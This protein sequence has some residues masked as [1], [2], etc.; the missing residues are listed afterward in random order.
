[1]LDSLVFRI[2]WASLVLS[3]VNG[4]ECGCEGRESGAGD[5][6]FAVVE[7]AVVH[8]GDA[9]GESYVVVPDEIADGWCVDDFIEHHF[10][11]LSRSVR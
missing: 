6:E 10:D 5:L 8:G 1:M 9:Y 3:G 7:W 4:C 2:R 11:S